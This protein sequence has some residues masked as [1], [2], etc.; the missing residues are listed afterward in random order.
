MSEAKIICVATG[1]FP[2]DTGGPAK[3]AETFL[4]WCQQNNQKVEAVSF[5][6]TATRDISFENTHVK[7]ISRNQFLL[8]RYIKTVIV[9]SR[10]LL[11]KRAVIAN[12]LFLEVYFASLITSRRYI[13]KVPGDIVW[14]RA[15]NTGYTNKSLTEFQ[16]ET[17]NIK[18]KLFRFL[19]SKSL[20][21]ANRVIVPTRQLQEMCLSWGVQLEK[22]SVIPNSVD[23]SL[24]SRDKKSKIQ[25]D[26]ISVGRLIGLKNVEELI[27]ACAEL[28]LSLAVV[29]DGPERS[30]LE[31]ISKE[32]SSYTVFF[33]NQIQE[34][35][36][37]LLQ[38]SNC[39][40]LNSS[41]EGGTPYS[42]LEARSVGLFSIA[43][44]G[45]GSSEVINHQVDGLLCGE[46]RFTLKKAL[47]V[48]VW[49]KQFV[50]EAQL[51][52]IMDT[53]TRFDSR[54]QFKRI[55]DIVIGDL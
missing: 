14:E 4:K 20:R 30:N 44:R 28:N 11:T 8:S 38:S 5:T 3:F 1:I 53:R 13:S 54:L 35:V 22:L 7:L 43:T 55:Q 19:Y 15:R 42:L 32:L 41:G 24:F 45:T 34:N 50:H 27:R 31:N 37:K 39:F 40:V 25:F 52:A 12:G 6:D 17:L 16:H 36:L 33:G 10:K 18:Y 29:G 2:P 46:D 23:T 49:D 51:K 26:V 47:E 21:R 48:F 9:L